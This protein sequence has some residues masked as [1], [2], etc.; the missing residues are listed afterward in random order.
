MITAVIQALEITS[1]SGNFVVRSIWKR[2]YII[3]REG[4]SFTHPLESTEVK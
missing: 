3:R 4:E 2:V 1:A